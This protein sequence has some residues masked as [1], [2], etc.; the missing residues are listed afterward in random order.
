[1]LS[2]ERKY[3]SH[4]GLINTN[5]LV[6]PNYLLEREREREREMGRRI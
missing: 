6:S 4:F 1:M 5:V 2:I 3:L